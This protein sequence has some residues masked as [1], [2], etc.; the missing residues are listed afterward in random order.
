M[1]HWRNTFKQPRF[2]FLD[3]RVGVFLVVFL[4]HVRLW[5]LLIMIVVFGIFFMMERYGLGF[6]SALRAVR[7]YFAGPIRH[8]VSEERMCQSAD[9]DR[10]PL[11]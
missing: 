1:A 6:S 11:F 9:F 3:A 7:A 4:L 8:P 5:T 10:R 2:F